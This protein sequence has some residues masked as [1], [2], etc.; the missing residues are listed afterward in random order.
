MAKFLKVRKP[1]SFFKWL[2][3]LIVFF[4]LSLSLFTI[5]LNKKIEAN[6]T[7]FKI[8]LTNDFGSY[9]LAGEINNVAVNFI[10]DSGAEESIL[11]EN[12]LLKIQEMTFDNIQYLPKGSYILAD[13]SE[14]YCQRINIRSMK[15]GEHVV[16]NVVFGIMPANT[17]CLLGKN[18]L[19]RYKRWSVN[20]NLN[21]LTLVR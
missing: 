5:I 9:R 2:S 21:E 1:L 14:V 6:D 12:L 11:T 4:T 19:D 18:V 7:H 17:D 15:I 16:M 13:G 3:I 10:L 20:K 8:P